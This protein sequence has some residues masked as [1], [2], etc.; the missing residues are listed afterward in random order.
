MSIRANFFFSPRGHKPL[1]TLHDR[2]NPQLC[3]QRRR[4]PIP[5]YAKRPDVT[6]RS[7]STTFQ[8]RPLRT[9][10]SRFPNTIRF[11]NRPPLV[12]MSAP[13]HKSLRPQC[14]LSAPT[15]SHLEGT[16]LRSYSM[17]WSLE[18]CP[19]D[20]KQDSVVYV[21]EFGV[22]LLAKGPRTVSIQ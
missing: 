20:L 12:R 13:A 6:V 21:A 15:P 3:L 4:F 7:Q 19:D 9:V 2:L 5:R 10:S 22:V 16:L 8:P 17:V 14:C 18:L 1:P 11:G